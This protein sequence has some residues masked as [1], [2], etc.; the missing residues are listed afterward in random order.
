MY[1]Q[2]STKVRACNNCCSRTAMNVTYSEC[3]YVALVIQHATRMRNIVICGLSGSTIFFHSISQT[4]RLSGKKVI[5][6]KMCL[7]ILSI[8]FVRDIFYSKKNSM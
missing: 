1:V 2:R 7:L 8:T 5:E 3:V 4:A 6:H